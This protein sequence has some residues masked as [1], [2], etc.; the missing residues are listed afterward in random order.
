MTPQL[1]LEL[2]WAGE[3]QAGIG[4]GITPQPA[5]GKDRVALH[6]VAKHHIAL[7]CIALQNA[8]SRCIALQSVALHFIAKCGFALHCIASCC[9]A[10]QYIALQNVVLCYVAK[11]LC[12][13]QR[14]LRIV[15]VTKLLCPLLHDASATASD[16]SQ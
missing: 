16:K 7:H 5:A 4:L 13:G 10:L 11:H 6:C 1:R 15:A 8:T 2:S 3:E 12:P 9:V 14:Q